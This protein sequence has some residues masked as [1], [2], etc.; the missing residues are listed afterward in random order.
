MDA[1]LSLGLA[2]GDGAMGGKPVDVWLFR[3]DGRGIMLLLLRGCL[4]EKAK[5]SS[6]LRD[7]ML[8][9]KDEMRSRIALGCVRKRMMCMSISAWGC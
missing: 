5:E 8:V 9:S 4:S 7:V 6:Q 3:K 1:R 2:S